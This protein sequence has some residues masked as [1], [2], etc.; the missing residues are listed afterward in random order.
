MKPITS[1]PWLCTQTGIYYFR[2]TAYTTGTY[3]TYTFKVNEFDSTSEITF[4]NPTDTST[5]ATGK[6]CSISYNADTNLFTNTINIY[7]CIGNTSLQTIASGTTNSG[8]YNFT[9]AAG[10]P[11]RSDYRIKITNYSNSSIYGYSK[12][13]TINGIASDIYESDDSVNRAKSISTDGIF[14]DRTIPKNDI[15]WLVFTAQKDSAY[16]IR[17]NGDSLA[18]TY[19]YLYSAAEAALTYSSGYSS[20]LVWTCPATGS[21][22][23]KVIPYSTSYYGSYKISVMQYSQQSIATFTNPVSTT[24]WNA[25][26]SYS[27]QWQADTALFGSY[28]KMALVLDTTTLSSIA[29]STSNKVNGGTYSWTIPSDKF[30]SGTNYRIRISSTTYTTIMAYSPAFTISGIVPDAFEPDDSAASAHTIVADTVPENHTMPY[31]DKDWYSFSAKADRLYN[32]KTNG[33]I[34][35]GIQLYSSDKQTLLTTANSSYT[36][37]NATL[38]WICPNAGTY[39]F[40]I[41]NGAYYGSY[42]TTLLEYDTSAYRYVITA[43]LAT[44]TIT[45]GDIKIIQWTAATTFTGNV[46]IFLY[47]SSGI[48]TTL[49]SNTANTGTFSWTVSSSLSAGTY[50]IKVSNVVNSKIFGNSETFTIK[51]P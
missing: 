46:D 30:S 16:V 31:L 41:S 15:D 33:S 28:V 40:L 51:A 44:D 36:D 21:Y 25:G 17:I 27:I 9:L 12:L 13:F 18:N 20:K 2:I 50:Y 23:L 47:N 7:L 11:T 19:L 43:P 26:S 39:Y 6:T 35:T 38:L 49:I 5:W 24:T 4:T 22:Y 34:H 42:Q 29:A 3:G 1:N 48:P 37:T 10:L 32:I 45:T 8:T 14:Q